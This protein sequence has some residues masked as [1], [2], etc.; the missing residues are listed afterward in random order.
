MVG[1]RVGI[2]VLVAVGVLT[3]LTTGAGLLVT[4]PLDAVDS[5]DR[6]VAADL[7][8][9]RTATLDRVTAVGGTPADTVPVAVVWVAAMVGLGW[10]SRRWEV[11]VFLLAAVG[12][13]KLT[14][15]AA[16]LLVDRP[17][18]PVPPLGRVFATSSF[19]SGHVASAITLYGGLVVV[20][21]WLGAGRERARRPLLVAA[22]AVGVAVLA[23]VVAVSRTY[24]GHH[25]VSDVV[26]GALLGAAW[27][28][29]AWWLVLRPA[30]PPDAGPARAR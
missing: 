15:L 11:A 10:W 25:Y 27:L 21:L 3:L 2:P 9:A 8:E 29:L 22:A 14:Y 23:V 17:R 19:P 24:R 1:R 16:S 7:V 12:G 26:W 5:F 4:G 13:E 30:R 6:T 20:G 28:W 18:P